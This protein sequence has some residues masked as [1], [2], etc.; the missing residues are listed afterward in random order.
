MPCDALAA[1]VDS[2][3]SQPWIIKV[4][5]MQGKRGMLASVLCG[6]SL[7][8]ACAAVPPLEAPPKAQNPQLDFGQFPRIVGAIIQRPVDAREFF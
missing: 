3:C 1:P 2:D 5:E 4:W 6:L 7:L 8:A